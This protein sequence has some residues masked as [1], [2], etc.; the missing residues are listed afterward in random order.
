MAISVAVFVGE[1]RQ[2]IP[3]LRSAMA[4][5]APGPWDSKDA[6]FGPL[7]LRRSPAEAGRRLAEATMHSHPHTHRHGHLHAPG[8]ESDHVHEAPLHADHHAHD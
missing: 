7:N 1:A 4:A 8:L 2:W 5:I 6:A 3:E